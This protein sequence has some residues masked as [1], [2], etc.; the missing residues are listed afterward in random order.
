MKKISMIPILLAGLI[1]PVFGM[2]QEETREVTTLEEVV[3]T[4]GRVEE[5]KKEITTNITTIDEEEVKASSAND[6]GD[7]LAEKG[8][9]HIQ[10]YPGSLTSVGIR[11]FRTDATGNDLM[12][13]VLILL[14]GRRA[15]TGNV[16]K[17]L[18]KNIEKVEVIRGPASVQYGSAAMGG[19][20]N[21]ITKQGD[22][23]P[24]F[25]A[26]GAIGSFGYREADAGFIGKIKGIDFSGSFSRNSTDD[27]STAEGEKYYNTGYSRK[28][29]ISLNLGFE[30]LPQH[31][32]GIIYN[33]FDSNNV[34]LP[35]YLSQNDLDDYKDAGNKSID[36]IYEGASR[37][38]TFSWSAR[39]FDGEDDGMCFDPVGSNPDFW[40]DD[41]PDKSV[42]DHQG[43]QA[44]ISLN[45][46]SFL[47]TSGIDWIN[48]KT[49]DD[50]YSPKETTYDNP[51]LYLLAKKKFFNNRFI[52]TGGLR[53]DDY[54]VEVKKG[55]GGKE[56]DN[57]ISP[58]VGI[59][60]LIKDNLKLRANYGEAFRMPSANELAGNYPGW[61][62]SYIGNPA[63]NPEKSKNYEGGM[64]FYY[65]SFSAGFTFFHTEFNDKIQTTLTPE[66][67]TTW[68]NIGE[69]E[70]E[71]VE[72]NV[73][74]DVGSLFSWD[75]QVKPYI[76][77]TYLNKYK[78][79]ET[80]ENL[81][82]TSDLNISCGIAVSDFDG[83]SANLNFAYTGKQDIDDWESG[84]PAIVEEKGGFVVA[85]FTVSKTIIRSEKYGGVTVGGEI[86]NLFNKDYSYV[87]GYPM[88]E[89]SFLL[90][91]GFDF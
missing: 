50:T 18:T 46:E 21:V 83:F 52:L 3:V 78:D 49:T 71:G 27:Y 56:S 82:Y 6:L 43:A 87:K 17:I 24:T 79:N 23:K 81:K 80:G 15:G 4:A 77:F 7:L 8:I 59:A 44:Q 73:S 14:N 34:G 28:E 90:S 48:Y 45:K 33:Y 13:H 10:K 37:D 84:W 62:G 57:N 61:I 36:F 41:I 12:G 35:N 55:E 65:A 40:D 67:N 72:T 19:V 86:K 29:N 32:I 68:E 42:V 63:L 38:E 20:V 89:R 30:F 91:L 66:G 39:Y 2:S 88:P 25:F 1:L 70:I 11:G 69:A 74:Y 9:G 76:D 51:A 54:E 64:D 60:Y 31:R 47:I 26:E 58:R 5:K 22:G 16:A 75:L 85:D 53:Y